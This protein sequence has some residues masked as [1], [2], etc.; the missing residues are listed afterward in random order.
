MA[1]LLLRGD[2]ERA[3][4]DPWMLSKEK[5]C[6]S[7]PKQK[8][9]DRL[10]IE[11]KTGRVPR[12]IIL[13]LLPH[14][15][16]DAPLLPTVPRVARRALSCRNVSRPH[17]S[18]DLPSSVAI[19]GREGDTARLAEPETFTASKDSVGHKHLDAAPTTVPR[20]ILS[21]VNYY[22]IFSCFVFGGGDE[23][24]SLS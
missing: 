10:L 24:L 7:R 17:P 14:L 21:T 19:T 11:T 2:H 23:R 5:N 8:R 22:I 4:T 13:M 1:A 20:L 3:A 6:G 12:G 18:R 9:Y 15:R 16:V